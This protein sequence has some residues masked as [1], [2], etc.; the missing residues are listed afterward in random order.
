MIDA[1]SRRGR[2]SA[3]GKQS[4]MRVDYPIIGMVENISADDSRASEDD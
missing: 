4:G 1:P 2:A 3:I